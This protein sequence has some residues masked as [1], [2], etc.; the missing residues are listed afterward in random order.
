[1]SVDVVITTHRNADKLK[2][3]LRSVIE[4]TKFVDYKIYLLANDPNEAIKKVIHDSMFVDDILF[5]DRIEPIFN[6]NNDGSFSTNN[7]ETAAEGKAPYILFLNDDCEPI[8]EDWLLNMKSMLDKDPK[9]GVVGALLLYP[10]Q[11]IIQHCGVFFS[12]RTNGLPYHMLYKQP[13]KKVAGFISVPR[14]YQAVTAACM[15][16]RRDDF[17]KVGGFSKDYQYGYEDSQLCLDL[18]D[19]CDRR[20]IYTPSAQLIHHEGISGAFKQHPSLQDN[21][22]AFRKN[23]SGRYINDYEFYMGDPK[24]MVYRNK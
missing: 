3:C 13:V 21:I 2:I 14:Y 17:E 11:K 20:I 7:N 16:V 12:Q 22:K 19:K 9:L 5:T 15:L 1:M 10:G 6:D 24:F 23:C 8:N 4:K 18:K